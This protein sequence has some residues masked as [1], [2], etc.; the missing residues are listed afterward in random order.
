MADADVSYRGTELSSASSYDLHSYSQPTR[1]L[2]P[3]LRWHAAREGLG[4]CLV[5]LRLPRNWVLVS[6][7]ATVGVSTE[8]WFRC[9]FCVPLES[10]LELAVHFKS[11]CSSPP[12]TLKYL[13][14]P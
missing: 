14:A 1:R 11:G 12:Y 6:L 13:I 4:C 7:S 3:D 2:T 9:R 10:R 5:N 8:T